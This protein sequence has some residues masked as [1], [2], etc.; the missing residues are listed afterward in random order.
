MVS[1]GFKAP[2]DKIV[3]DDLSACDGC[4]LIGSGDFTVG[5]ATVTS[6]R[7]DLKAAN[8]AALWL[9]CDLLQLNSRV[10]AYVTEEG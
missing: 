6:F 2:S 1:V 4:I 9:T 8:H 3:N 5:S 10:R 7:G